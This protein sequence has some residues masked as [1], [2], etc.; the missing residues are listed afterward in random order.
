M[1]TSVKFPHTGFGV[2]VR[3]A[4]PPVG[5]HRPFSATAV[6]APL[7][8]MQGIFDRFCRRAI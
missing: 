2:A 7:A 4:T 1:T 6:I 5:I 8:D 3:D